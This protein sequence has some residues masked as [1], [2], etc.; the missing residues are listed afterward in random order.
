VRAQGYDWRVRGRMIRRRQLWTLASVDRQVQRIFDVIKRLGEE[1]TLAFYMSD[2]GFLWGQHGLGEDKR[3][4][5]TDSVRVPFFVRWPGHLPAGAVDRSIVANVDV[6]PTILDAA[7]LAPA[8]RYPLDGHS[9][10]APERRRGLL[11][12]YFTSPDGVVGD[13]AAIRTLRY[14]YIE[15]LDVTRSVVLFREYYDLGADPWE[16]ENRYRNG[17]PSDHPPTRWM[18]R[19]L[20]AAMACEGESCRWLAASPSPRLEP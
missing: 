19:R 1:N 6:L 2:N 20:A 3:Y 5:Y 9:L 13:W 4:P 7:E 11:L 10:F 12:E 17:T 16:L 8:L 18:H 14:H 15:W